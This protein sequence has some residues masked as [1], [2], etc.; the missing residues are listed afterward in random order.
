MSWLELILKKWILTRSRLINFLLLLLRLLMLKMALIFWINFVE[1]CIVG[2][3]FILC[4]GRIW[5][6]FLQAIILVDNIWI[7]HF[8]SLS[9][10]SL[11][12]FY[13]IGFGHSFEVRSNALSCHRWLPNPLCIIFS[14]CLPSSHLWTSSIFISLSCLNQG[15]TSSILVILDKDIQCAQLAIV[16]VLL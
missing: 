1:V 15:A 8:L 11:F 4:T 3:I 5:R 12:R 10:L 2:R 6:S 14:T 9:L 16:L 13:R 7:A